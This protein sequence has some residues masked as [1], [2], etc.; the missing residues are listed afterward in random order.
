MRLWTVFVAQMRVLTGLLSGPPYCISLCGRI[1]PL[2][3]R[4]TGRFDLSLMGGVD[5]DC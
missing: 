4:T 1:I 2:R 3:L 5:E